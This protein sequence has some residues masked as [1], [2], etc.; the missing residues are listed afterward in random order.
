[1]SITPHKKGSLLK[2]HQ[3]PSHLLSL[4]VPYS[5]IK[6]TH[7]NNRKGYKGGEQRGECIIATCSFIASGLHVCN[8]Q[9][10]K[11]KKIIPTT[12]SSDLV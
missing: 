6:S 4:Y 7:S 1:M 11:I 9:I 8:E 5:I 12:G 2:S 3:F 10:K